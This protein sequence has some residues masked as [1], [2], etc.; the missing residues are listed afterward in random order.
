MYRYMEERMYTIGEFSKIGKAS[1]KMLRHYDKIGLL[2]PEYINPENRYRYYSKN[3]IKDILLINR[4]K[5]YCFSLDEI[6]EVLQ[7]NDYKHLKKKI[8][9]KLLQ[10][11]EEIRNR[12]FLLLEMKEELKLLEKGEDIMTSKRKFDITLD[13][14]KPFTVLSI[15]D[16]IAMDSISNLIGKVFESIHKYGL[17]PVGECMTIYYDKDFDADNTEVEVCVPVN[18]EY[19]SKEISTRII[20]GG[21]HLHTTFIGSYSEIGE[22]YA[23][24][25]DWIKENDYETVRAPF[26]RYIKGPGSICS[27]KDFVTEVYFPVRKI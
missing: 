24:L 10:L 1:T 4:L 12:Q 22:A 9:E 5:A 11:A 18:R 3:Q 23:A 19:K 17:T 15:R 16:R 21:L 13:E 25:M 8:E 14:L 27:P 2:R 26:E 6:R 20:D 7:K